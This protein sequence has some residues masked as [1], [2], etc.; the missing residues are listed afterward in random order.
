MRII[1]KFGAAMVLA[2]VIASGLM[3]GTAARRSEGQGGRRQHE[4]CG[5]CLPRVGV[6][7]SLREPDRR[8]VRV[9]ALHRVRLRPRPHPLGAS[10]RRARQV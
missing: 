10:R 7:L 6:E 8:T 5:L 9:G 4:R 2:G 1:R 3:I